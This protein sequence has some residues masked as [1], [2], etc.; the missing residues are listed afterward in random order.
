MS[1]FWKNWLTL[2]A[3]FVTVFG[4]VLALGAFPATDGIARAL[5]TLFGSPLPQP[6]DADLRFCLGLM[7]AVTMGWGLSY[8]VLFAA[9]ARVPRDAAAKLWRMTLAASA[10]WFVVDSTISIATRIPLNAVSNTALMIALL[11]PLLA[12]GALTGASN[13]Q[14]SP[15]SPRA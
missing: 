12:S 14:T 4:V 1:S 5:F 3:A 6:M 13:R 8:A 9:I 10:V 7:G 15:L 2:W 11:V